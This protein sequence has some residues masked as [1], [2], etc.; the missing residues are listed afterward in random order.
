MADPLSVAAGVA[1]LVSLGVQVTQSLVDFYTPYRDQDSALAA[2]IQKLESLSDIFQQL[3]KTL[4]S[5]RYEAAERSLIKKVENAIKDCD[6]F[7]EELQ[8]EY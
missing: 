3:E 7:L 2:T 1:G 5:R 6:E 4:A 8:D